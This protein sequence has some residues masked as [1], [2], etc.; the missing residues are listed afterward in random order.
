MINIKETYSKYAHD[1][2]QKGVNPDIIVVSDIIKILTEDDEK[3]KYDFSTDNIISGP[4]GELIKINRKK[5]TV[6]IYDSYTVESDYGLKEYNYS[7]RIFDLNT[8][9]LFEDGELSSVST[10]YESI[11]LY[12]EDEYN[13]L[14]QLSNEDFSA[15]QREVSLDMDEIDIR[16]LEQANKAARDKVK[17]LKDKLFK[18]AKKYCKKYDYINEGI[19][20]IIENIDIAYRKHS[21]MKSFSSP[22]LDE[23]IVNIINR[24]LYLEELTEES[25]AFSKISIFPITEI[26]EEYKAYH[27]PKTDKLAKKYI[28]ISRKIAEVLDPFIYFRIDFRNHQMSS[29]DISKMH[30]NHYKKLIK[31]RDELDAWGTYE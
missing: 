6:E 27:T 18:T 8:G 24:K 3:F 12:G 29:K 11:L 7:V 10:N 17:G 21:E 20:K 26:I 14:S 23:D 28:F 2:Y 13:Y 5:G 25:E 30:N 31:R 22:D 4:F 15:Y 1:L 19:T 9:L 16:R